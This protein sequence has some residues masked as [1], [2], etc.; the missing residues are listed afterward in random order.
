VYNN[1]LNNE[2]GNVTRKEIK[3]AKDALISAQVE[4]AQN[5]ADAQEV[6]DYLY[7]LKVTNESEYNKLDNLKDA[8]NNEIDIVINLYGENM[9]G[10]NVGETSGLALFSGTYSPTAQTDNNTKRATININLY[11]FGKGVDLSTQT[12]YQS[13]RNYLT[14][15]N[16]LGD[17]TYFFENVKD[18]TSYDKWVNSAASGST[19]YKS[20][21]TGAGV[22]SSE[23]EANRVADVKNYAKTNLKRG[24]TYNNVKQTIEKR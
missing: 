12:Q 20:D 1:L 24:E 10:T 15:A 3:R 2:N 14:F 6:D 16:E 23:Y 17:I 21:P 13:G 18:K 8:N 19:G 4:L 9:N 7:T 11:E 5:E 22:K